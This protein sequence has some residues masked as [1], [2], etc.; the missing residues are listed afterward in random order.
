VLTSEFHGFTDSY[1]ML[2][3][4]IGWRFAEGRALVSLRGTNLTNEKILQHVYGDLLRRSIVAE[5]SFFT[6]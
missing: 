1:T 4:T 2:N 5:L 6:R 3:A